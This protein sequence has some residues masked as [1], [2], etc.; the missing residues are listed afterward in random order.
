[1]FIV[2]YFSPKTLFKY[3][4]ILKHVAVTSFDLCGFLPQSAVQRSASTDTACIPN[5]LLMRKWFSCL[6]WSLWF[7]LTT[8]THTHESCVSKVTLP[9]RLSHCYWDPASRSTTIGTSKYTNEKSRTHICL[10]KH[11]IRTWTGRDRKYCIYRP[12]FFCSDTTVTAVINTVND[13][14]RSTSGSYFSQ[15]VAFHNWTF[16]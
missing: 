12:T 14:E 2:K 13:H 1:M 5:R 3:L 15:D 10:W 6:M 7:G 16:Q 8:H 9:S 11:G 4:I